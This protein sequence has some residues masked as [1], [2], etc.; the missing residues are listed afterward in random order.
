MMMFGVK[1]SVNFDLCE[2][3]GLCCALAPEVFELRDDG[4]LYVLDENPP[5]SMR[6]ELEEA[7]LSCPK[8][9]ISIDS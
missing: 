6:G 3:N 8:L 4:Y 7:V 1:V 2:S 9:A 5:E